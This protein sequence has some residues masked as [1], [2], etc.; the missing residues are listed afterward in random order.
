MLLVPS[1][2]VMEKPVLNVMVLPVTFIIIPL[3]EVAKNVLPLVKL[4]AKVKLNVMIV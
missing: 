2:I 3:T 1:V 4:A